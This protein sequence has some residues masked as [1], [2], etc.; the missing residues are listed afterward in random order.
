MNPI[1][2]RI[3]VITVTWNNAAG[4]D[5]TLKSLCGLEA[6]PVEIL[7]IDGASTDGTADIAERYASQ[8]PIRFI[9]E[10]DKGIY[11]AMNKGHRLATGDLIH[12]LNAGDVAFGEPYADGD[13][14]LLPVR[15]ADEHG[16]FQ[17][18]DYVKHGGYGYC[19]QG[20]LFPRSHPAYRTEYRIAAD[21]DLI[22]AAF[23]Q[24]L[25][26]LPL[27]TRG[28]VQF[29]LGG[30]SNQ[31]SRKRDAEII[32][33]ARDRLPPTAAQRLVR[34]IVIKNMIPRPLRRWIVKSLGARTG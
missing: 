10:P 8:L 30:I 20:I 33:I 31:A 3:S 4:L 16:V 19:H 2:P 12:Y 18:E 11:D 7:V 9:S 13:A 28:G 25:R 14:R 21:F 24:G 23:P 15:I 1:L 32:A 26:E 27:A 22:V 29:G 6:A 34:S 17:F 5:A